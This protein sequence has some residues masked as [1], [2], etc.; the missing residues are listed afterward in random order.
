MAQMELASYSGWRPRSMRYARTSSS[1]DAQKSGKRNRLSASNYDKVLFTSAKGHLKDPKR[2][3]E[4]SNKAK[5][6]NGWRT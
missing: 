5:N 2:F 4:L 3:E 1:S 6:L